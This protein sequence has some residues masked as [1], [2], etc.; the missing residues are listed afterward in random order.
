MVTWAFEMSWTT[1]WEAQHYIPHKNQML[2]ITT[3]KTSNPAQ[4]SVCL[5]DSKKHTFKYNSGW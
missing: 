1:K 3:L 4:D 2:I 5:P